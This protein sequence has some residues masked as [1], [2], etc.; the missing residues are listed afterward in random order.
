NGYTKDGKAAAKACIEAGIDIEM[1]STH[2]INYGKELVEEGALSLELI[3]QAVRNILTLKDELGLFENPYKDADE[4][5]EKKLHKCEDHVAKARKVARECVVMLKNEQV[6]PLK[7]GLKVGIAGP[8]T[9]SSDTMGGWSLTDKKN[10]GTLGAELEAHGMQ[11]VTAMDDEI[12][13]MQDGF[14]DVADKVEEA[15]A[16]LKDC[17]VIITAVGEHPCD[18]GESASRTNIRLSPNQEKLIT[19]LHK[20]GKPIVAILFSG[21]PL[22]IAPV[23]PCCDAVLQG[24]FLGTE[25][26]GALADILMGVANPSAR[27]SM[28]F[29]QTVGQIPVHYNCYNT[30]R[31]NYG[32]RHRYVSCYL[33]CDNEPLYPFGYGLSYGEVT[34]TD[35]EVQVEGDRA[36]AKVKV[37]NPSAYTIKETVQLYI[38]DLYAS[39]VR[40]VKE[41][42][43]FKQ[44]TL[45]P[46]AS[47]EVTFEITKEMLMFYNNKLEYVF[48]AGEFDIMIGKNSADVKHQIIEMA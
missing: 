43:G 9:A 32:K 14:F 20:L 34:Y 37:S 36:L 48:E 23:L 44:V 8:F 1:M 46:G 38:R 31:P 24:W 2:Y 27:L 3:D 29:P 25:S 35:F 17:D 10:A 33:D 30:G 47:E 19:E 16:A 6:L 45:T 11:V 41:L 21:R 18:T 28:S 13:P 40:P 5:M 4:E 7:S 12:K 26:S 39:V 42:K 22:E 15:V